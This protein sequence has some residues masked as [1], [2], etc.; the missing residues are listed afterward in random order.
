MQQ[1][2]LNNILVIDEIPTIA[3]GL[4]AVFRSVHPAAT[5]DSV[6]NIFTAL[7][8]P[9]FEK[10]K[11]DLIVLGSLPDDPSRNLHQPIKELKDRF[12]GS[13][14]MVYTTLYDHE[15]IEKMETLHIDAYVHKFEAIEE[16]RD[17]YIRLT[18]DEN[19]ISNMLYTLFFKYQLGRL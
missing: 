3:L 16:V 14:I 15:L 19:C 12:D 18:A 17:I 5:V 8:A 9:R 6:E 10:K 13:R 2:P 7:S 1:H 4:Q 11:F